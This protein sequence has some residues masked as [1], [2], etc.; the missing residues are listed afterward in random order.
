MELYKNGLFSF[1][2]LKDKIVYVCNPKFSFNKNNQLHNEQKE[3][4]LWENGEKYYFLN[5]VRV[6]EEIVL[7]PAEKL[8][9]EL[10]IKENNAEV[11][12]EI[13]RKIGISR[14]LQKLEAKKLDSWREYELYRIEN[15][16]IE[17]VQILK[18][19]CPSKDILYTLRVSPEIKTAREAI[20]WVNNGIEPEQ[21]LV[22]A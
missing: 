4:I 18:M 16:D 5:G 7:I 3:A 6:N 17:P 21:F 20:V 22:E 9:P 2:V 8:N 15:I 19:V 12:K 11:R 14:I 10:L 13:I 1:W